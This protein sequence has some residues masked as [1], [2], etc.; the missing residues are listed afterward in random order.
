MDSAEGSGVDSALG[1]GVVSAVGS[2]EAGITVGASAGGETEFFVGVFVGFLFGAMIAVG[3]LVGL[4]RMLVSR[5]LQLYRL[6]DNLPKR[7][8]GHHS[9]QLSFLSVYV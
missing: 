1:S 5:S 3:F 6:L 7:R 4:L 8:C 9:T 2:A